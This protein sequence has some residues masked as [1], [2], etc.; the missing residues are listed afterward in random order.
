MGAR[1]AV[2]LFPPHR[3]HGCSTAR[4]YR[5][6]VPRS[7]R[8]RRH[9]VR[10]DVDARKTVA[11]PPLAPIAIPSLAR[12]PSHTYRFDTEPTPPQRLRRGF[13]GRHVRPVPACNR[14]RR[15]PR[16]PVREGV[17]HSIAAGSPEGNVSRSSVVPTSDGWA[18]QPGERCLT[19]R[20]KRAD[21]AVFGGR[22]PSGP[23]TDDTSQRVKIGS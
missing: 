21:S 18:G 15:S 1:V 7:R 6:R 2:R 4:R 12:K 17:C 20:G 3:L 16:S 11:A 13:S 5:R 19:A 9:R 10:H 22:P 8:P 23:V 14:S